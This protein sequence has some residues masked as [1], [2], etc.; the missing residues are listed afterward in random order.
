MAMAACHK[1]SAPTAGGP[2]SVGDQDAMWK[3]APQGAMFGLVASGKGLAQLESGWTEVMKALQTVPPLQEPLAKLQAEMQKEIGTDKL[4]LDALGLSA[5]S[6]AAIFMTP[7]KEGVFVLPVVDRDKFLKIAKGEK[8]ADGTDHIG[9]KRDTECKTR[10]GMYTCVSNPKM[11]DLIGKGKLD[12]SAA[13]ARG[14]IEFVGNHLPAGPRDQEISAAIVQQHARGTVTWR[15]KITGIPVPPNVGGQAVKPRTEGDNT[16]GFAT[17][18]LANVV[19]MMTPMLHGSSPVPG[20]DMDALIASIQDPITM[21]ATSSSIDVQVPLGD[22]APMKSLLDQCTVLGAAVG[23]KVVDG[24]CEFVAPNLPN[25]PVDMWL[26]GKTLH[27]GQKK[28]AKGNAIPQSGLGK[29]LAD[30]SWNYAFYGR[31]SILGAGAMLA[32]TGAQTLQMLP[33]DLAP[34]AKEAVRMFLVV[35]EIG[36]GVKI[37]GTTISF[38]MGARTMWANDDDVVAKLVALSGDDILSGKA[39]EQAKTFAKGPLAEDIKAGVPGLMAPMSVVG[40]LAAVSVPA[41]MD[42][43]K[44]AKVTEFSLQLNKIGKNAKRVYIETSA[45]PVGESATIPS[46]TC[47]GQPNNKCQ[48]EPEAFAKDPIWSALE[49]SIDEPSLYRYHYKSDGKTATVEAVGDVDCDGSEATAVLQLDSANGNPTA[50]I[51]PPPKGV[52]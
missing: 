9:K 23:A 1:S 20:V 17:V 41:Y 42:Y 35:N 50:T 46:K 27:V 29:E 49:F 39:G 15:G 18:N 38:V 24:A 6:G 11:W 8:G 37:D 5:K 19:K 22:A 25:V 13:G 7:D 40:V 45:F 16:A 52:Y 47:C 33:P 31:G 34:I 44:R 26:D 36:L 43:M 4:S 28:A 2:G 12:I 10:E 30:G 3:L 51:T 32:T 14:E 21:A 48:P